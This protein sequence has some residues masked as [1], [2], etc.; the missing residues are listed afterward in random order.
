MLK[1]SLEVTKSLSE[2][3]TEDNEVRWSEFLKYHKELIVRAYNKEDINLYKSTWRKKFKDVSNILKYTIVSE[4]VDIWPDIEAKL[5][6][7]L[8]TGIS[9]EEF[10]VAGGKAVS[11]SISAVCSG[12]SVVSG[13]K[14]AVPGNKSAIPGGK[15]SVSDSKSASA[16]GKSAAV[17]GK[18]AALGRKYSVSGEGFAVTSGRSVASGRESTIA[19]GKSA[20]NVTSFD[21]TAESSVTTVIDSSYQCNDS[22][23]PIS[24]SSAS[25]RSKKSASL[26][27]KANTI[28]YNLS[29]IEKKEVISFYESIPIEDKWKLSS[30]TMVENQMKKL[31]EASVYEHPV[32]SFIMDPYD[33][34][35]RDYFTN[36]ELKQIVSIRNLPLKELPVELS[37]FMS[38]F[39]DQTTAKGIYKQ[40]MSSIVDPI[41][42]HDKK[43]VQQSMMH[44]SELFFIDHQLQISGFSEADATHRI[45]PFVYRLFYDGFIEAKLGEKCSAATMLARNIER[46]LEAVEKRPRK[47]MGARMDILFKRGNVELGCSEIGKDNVSN[48]DDKYLADALVKLPKTLRNMLYAINTKNPDQINNVCTVGLLMMGTVCKYSKKKSGY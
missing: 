6:D 38:T 40:S 17:G 48:V 3:A 46:N 36:D 13:T 11:G 43:W 29:D 34:I 8:S 30:G 9:G 21:Y 41:K 16:G 1:Y 26:S 4:R 24:K 39:N 32:H 12:G 27:S 25:T 18:S 5:K 28:N 47:A 20:A 14:Y 35:W 44:A 23:L 10:A 42:E 19:D 31:A 45:W 15:S 22:S 7:I 2:I 33:P 37:E